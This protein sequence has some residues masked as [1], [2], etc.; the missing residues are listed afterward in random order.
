MLALTPSN[1]DVFG[2]RVLTV[3]DIQTCCVRRE[4]S[5]SD[6]VEQFR[7]SESETHVAVVT[8]AGKLL[9][10]TI[11]HVEDLPALPVLQMPL[12][13]SVRSC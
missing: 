2:F 5:F 9:L 1:I 10:Y 13:V 12:K 11:E 4:M 3:W 7:I 8:S 6:G